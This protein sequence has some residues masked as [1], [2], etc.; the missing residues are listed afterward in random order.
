LIMALI[1]GTFCAVIF[2]LFRHQLPYV[3][4]DDR[5]VVSMAAYLLLF[6]ALF[7]ISDSTQSISAG[8]LRG[9]KDVKIPTFFIAIAYWA[10]GIPVGCLLA[11]YYKMGAAGIWMGFITG[12][13]FSAAFLTF[14]FKKMVRASLKAA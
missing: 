9:I 8:L 11:F 13:T 6:A 10:I 2:I 5:E 12:L 1:Y 4:N 14:R 3:F 7:Q